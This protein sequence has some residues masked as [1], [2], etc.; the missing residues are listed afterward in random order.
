M[1]AQAR[2]F[3]TRNLRFRCRALPPFGL[4]ICTESDQRLVRKIRIILRHLPYQ[5]EKQRKR[6]WRT[7]VCAFMLQRTML[8]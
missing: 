8:R 7:L 5:F 6:A 2:T 1:I 4:F 3:D